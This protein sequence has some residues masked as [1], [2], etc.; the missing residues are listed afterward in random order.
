MSA[1]PELGALATRSD[2]A[3]R[4]RGPP[5]TRPVEGLTRTGLAIVTLAVLILSLNQTSQSLVARPFFEWLGNFGE[6]VAVNAVIGFAILLAAVWARERYPIPG[7]AQY[8][9]AF[10]AVSITTLVGVV[11]LNT[12]HYAGLVILLAALWVRYYPGRMQYACAIIAVI[13][14]V[15][16]AVIT[17][18]MALTE[19]VAADAPSWMFEFMI[20]TATDLSRYAF[21]AL[22]ITGAWLYTRTEAD[23]AAAIAQCVVDASRM[24]EQTAEARLQMLEAQIEPHFLFNTLAHVQHLYEADRAAGA[25]MLRNLKDYLGVALPEMRATQSTLGR[26]LG[27]AAAYLGIQQI[28]MGRRLTYGIDVD[29]DLR[30]ARLPPL[31]LVTLVENAIKHGLTPVPGGGRIDIRARLEGGR[32]HVE[33]ADSGQG[34]TKSGGA[35]TGLSNIRARLAAQFGEGASLALAMNS[36]RGVV[37][38]IALPYLRARTP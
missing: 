11:A 33:V 2:A 37:A 19:Q 26:E 16:L 4:V 30:D 34:F 8:A 31:M 29:D 18:Q 24:D 15:A 20:L 21:I 9:I 32:L 5:G 3:D 22:V 7:R 23:H 17:S 12:S 25:L 13:A 38:T 36:P 28:R 35:G 27:H 1:A 10:L 14:A 6:G